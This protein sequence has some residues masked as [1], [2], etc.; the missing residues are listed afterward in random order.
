M[1]DPNEKFDIGGLVRALSNLLQ[2][3][4][5]PDDLKADFAIAAT[6]DSIKNRIADISIATHDCDSIALKKAW[7]AHLQF[8]LSGI[9]AFA[10][11]NGIEPPEEVD[12]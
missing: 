4:D 3:S 12:E 8:V 6:M 9:N 7:L 5:A 11:G 2:E 1:K 10:D